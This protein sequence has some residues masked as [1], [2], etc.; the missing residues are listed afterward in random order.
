MK[1]ILGLVVLV[2]VLVLTSGVALAAK[3]ASPAPTDSGSY[4]STQ[5]TCIKAAQDK[6]FTA[7]KAATTTLNNAAKGA[8]DTRMAAMK[9]ATDILNATAKDALKTRTD[10]IA[11]AQKIQDPTAKA[12]AIKAASDA[13]NNNAAV[14]K[15]KPAYMA[16]MKAASDEYNSNADVAKAKPAYTAAMKAANDQ[17][18]K[19]QKACIQG[20]IG[21][22][23]MLKNFTAS[24][25]NSLSGLIKFFSGKK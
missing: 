2:S 21:F 6:R 18:Q 23:G 11:A 15:A 8:F 16:A 13:Y 9:A 14:K 20:T 19:D 10:A 4:T 12:A 7:M 25:S 22:N 3:K 24:I 5:Q 17:F 1:K